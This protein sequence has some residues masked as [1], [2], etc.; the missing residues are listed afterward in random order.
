MKLE[1]GFLIVAAMCVLGDILGQGL[2]AHFTAD[3][4]FGLGMLAVAFGFGAVVV[5]F[6]ED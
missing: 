2:I 5:R 3:M 6:L 1:Y 4:S